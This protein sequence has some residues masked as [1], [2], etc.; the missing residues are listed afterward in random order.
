MCGKNRMD[1]V[2]NVDIRSLVR[3]SPIEEKMRKNRLRWVGHIGR[4]SMD[5]PVRKIEKIDIKQGKK[6]R[7][8]PKMT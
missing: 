3:V 4:R 1:K 2:R 6:L 5:A 8:R 7:G